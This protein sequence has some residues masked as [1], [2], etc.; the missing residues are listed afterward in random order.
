MV[1]DYFLTGGTYNG[2]YWRHDT[3]ELPFGGFLDI[4][5]IKLPS[6]DLSLGVRSKYPTYWKSA[7]G[8]ILFYVDNGEF[9]LPPDC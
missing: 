7:S 5:S 9:R 2:T 1:E 6:Y 4:Y 8:A 3:T